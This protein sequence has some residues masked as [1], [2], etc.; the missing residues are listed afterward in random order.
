MAGG[1]DKKTEQPTRRKLKKAREKGQVARSRE[2]PAAAV[3]MG[4]I[5]IFYYFGQNFFHA[6][7]NEMA[8]LL[9]LQVPQEINLS[10]LS[11]M[12]RGVTVRTAAVLAPILIGVLGFSVLSNVLQ[13]GLAFS[14]HALKLKPEKL[15]PKNGFKK[16]FSKNGL[17][18]LVK[19]L[20]VVSALS[21]ITYQVLMSHLP[22]YPKLVL[23]NPGKILY[24][25]AS[26]SFSVL[27]RI[28][29]L[30]LVVAILDF[31]FQKY[32]F[33]EQMKMS[34]KEVREE[35]KEMEG[36][37]TTKGR[38]RRIQRAMARRRMMADV[39]KA[40]VVVTNPTHYAVALSYK[41]D[42]MEAPKVVAKGVGFLAQKIKELAQQHAIPLVENKPLAQALY[43][44]VE[45]G[46]Y[47]PAHL[48]R[49]VAEIL[50]YIYKAKTI[51]YR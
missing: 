17:V 31:C 16:I 48:Y 30:M 6:L 8:S 20:V 24:W 34:K 37:P 44:S 46:A 12:I 19:S 14:T 10:Y 33:R 27:I 11:T 4:V 3:L 47:I 39:P 25:T 42:E 26:I 50:A 41:T 38:I 43:K 5:L 51:L 35:Y 2:V 9:D 21:F 7:E 23:M 29:F 49:A 45:I 40:D 18:E 32:R 22:L 13:G 28:A 15:N 1:T 36:D